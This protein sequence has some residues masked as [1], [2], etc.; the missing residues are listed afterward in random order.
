VAAG[1]GLLLLLIHE[2]FDY[3]LHTPA[4]MV[5]FAL[6]A[7]I[8]FSAPGQINNATSRHRQR[9]RTPDLTTAEAPGGETTVPSLNPGAPPPEQIPNPFL[10]EP[11]QARVP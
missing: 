1:I 3:N 5:V 10:D 6:L 9:R 8:F 11:S 7:G 2:L 4:N